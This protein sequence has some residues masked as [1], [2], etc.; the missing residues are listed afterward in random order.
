VTRATRPQK[1]VLPATTPLREG[2][3]CPRQR[4]SERGV[5]RERA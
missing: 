1:G 2:R 4:P 5:G 3:C